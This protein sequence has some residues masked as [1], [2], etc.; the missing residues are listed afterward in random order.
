[1]AFDVDGDGVREWVQA[2][3]ILTA[4][5]AGADGGTQQS[6]LPLFLTM[7]GQNINSRV[8][9]DA[10]GAG[11]IDG[12]GRED[13]VYQNGKGSLSASLGMPGGGL[14]FPQAFTAAHF[15]LADVSGDGFPDLVMPGAVWFNDGHG[16]FGSPMSVPTTDDK[17]IAGDLNGDGTPDIIQGDRV[18]LSNGVV[19]FA[20]TQPIAPGISYATGDFNRDGRGDI[21]QTTPTT[22]GGRVLFQQADGGFEAGPP[23]GTTPPPANGPM[24]T[25]LNLDSW[26]DLIHAWS[27][28]ANTGGTFEARSQPSCR[29]ISAWG[30]FDNDGIID[31]QCA[32][33]QSQWV[34]FH[35]L[36]N[37]EFVPGP[38]SPADGWSGTAQGVAADFDGDGNLDLAWD[39]ATIHPGTG[40]G[41]LGPPEWWAAFDSFGRVQTAA[42]ID[43]DGRDDLLISSNPNG[44]QGTLFILRSV[45]R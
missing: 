18:H 24:V 16:V 39:F 1:V 17:M 43:G 30:D 23:L 6:V 5:A 14:R 35:G 27:W 32:D 19:A 41:S 40:T 2:R 28:S 29:S 15:V 4:T 13:L 37:G 25:D 11:D 26:P 20:S 31:L 10:V 9:I 34:F 12:D 21:V 38:V 8:R 7:Q 3:D 33:T 22:L 42:D 36:G 45:C 44:Y